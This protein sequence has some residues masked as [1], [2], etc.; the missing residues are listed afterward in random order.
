MSTVIS[1]LFGGISTGLLYA[2][3]ALAI[4]MLFNT[5]GFFN[6]A[7]GE[8]LALACY[9]LYQLLM[10]W[11]LPVW[12]SLVVTVCVLVGVG[13]LINV[14]LFS[15]LRKFKCKELYI[16]IATIALS[17]FLKNTIRQIWGSKALAVKGI[18]NSKS[19]NI[20][21]ANVMDYT[22]WI[23]GVSIVL[24]LMLYI[25][26][27]KT[28]LGIA[29]T[30]AAENLDAAS[31]MGVKSGAIIGL[32]FAISLGITAVAGILSTTVLYLQPEMGGSLATKAFAATVIGGFGNPVGAIIGGIIL[33]IVETSVAMV[34]PASY[35]NAIT[36]ALLIIFLI[37]KP[38]GLFKTRT[39]TKV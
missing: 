20:L 3:P 39:S 34:L 10:L 30:A 28:K 4:V 17:I 19:V 29:M 13:L 24:M 38:N 22:F 9:V 35:K 25:L 31:L 2:L 21:G 14:G 32:S 26:A 33:G 18:F 23:L 7:Q 27:K 11:N 12:L 15:L 6:L 5:A 36:F 1:V 16:L 37:F 8:L